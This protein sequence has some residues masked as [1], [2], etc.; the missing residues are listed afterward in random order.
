MAGGVGVAAVDGLHERLGKAHVDPA[1]VVV[2][3]LELGVCLL[4]RGDQLLLGRVH[5]EGQTAR[6]NRDREEPE[7]PDPGGAVGVGEEAGDRRAQQH[8]HKRVHAR[9]PPQLDGRGAMP[10]PQGER[11]DGELDGRCDPRRDRR[12]HDEVA[13]AGPGHGDRHRHRPEPCACAR[14]R[15]AGGEDHEPLERP[16]P[17]R[18][19]APH[20]HDR[21]GSRAVEDGGHHQ[22]DHRPR[23]LDPGRDPDRARL[24][25]EADDGQE[26]DRIHP[27]H[28]ARDRRRDGDQKRCDGERGSV[29]ADGTAAFRLGGCLTHTSYLTSRD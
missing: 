22:R 19:H 11:R 5:A 7:H 18:Q 13:Q 3:G 23:E 6:G 27:P 2:R 21:G 14:E 4:E 12:L 10:H 24:G 17:V 29:R 9:E 28:S 20:P 25:G 8:G 16:A 1:Q 26:R 15:A